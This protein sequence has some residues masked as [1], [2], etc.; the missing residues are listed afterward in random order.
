MGEWP[1]IMSEEV[2]TGIQHC[3]RHG[4]R[5]S[6]VNKESL[7]AWHLI[8][9]SIVSIGLAKAEHVRRSETHCKYRIILSIGSCSSEIRIIWSMDFCYDVKFM[10]TPGQMLL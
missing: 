8:V 3:K 10:F 2:C 5:A 1:E 6:I 9:G 4:N 7:K